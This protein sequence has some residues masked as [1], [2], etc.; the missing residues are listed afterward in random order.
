MK[1]QRK[2][3]KLEKLFLPLIVL[4]LSIL[5]LPESTPL[6]GAFTFGNFAKE[7][8]VVDRLSDTMQNALINIVTILLGLGVGSKLA[9][10]KF[11][12]GDTLGILILGLVAFA[13]GTAAGVL[14]AKFMNKFSDEPINPLIG[15]VSLQYQWR[16][17]SLT[18]LEW[19]RSQVTFC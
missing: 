18:K 1:Q 16:H 2:V 19:S 8:G 7:S 9:A 15:A 14:M 4:G 13:V 5:L 6:I 11:L 12:D 17:V 10:E 3:H